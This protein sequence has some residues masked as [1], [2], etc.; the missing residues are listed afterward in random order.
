MSVKII[1]KQISMSVVLLTSMSSLSAENLLQVYKHAL[2]ADPTLKAAEAGFLATMENKP[3]A[4]ASKK[5]QVGFSGSTSY[6]L[7]NVENTAA[8]GN[9]DSY[10]LG[11]DLSLSK[12]IYRKDLDALVD[13]ATAGVEQSRSLLEVERQ[14][15]IIRVADAYFSYLSALDSLEFATAEKQA[16]NR[17]LAQ[18]KAFFEAGRSPITD[19]KEA[20]ARYD[21]AVSQEVAAN[22]QL[23]LAN[24]QI[25][26]IT[27][28]Y[29]KSLAR[30]PLD[31]PLTPPAPNKIEAWTKMAL[32]NSSEIRALKYAVD[33]AQAE[34]DRQRAVKKPTV[35]LFARQS[36]NLNR[37]DI[38]TEQ[39][40]ASLGVQLS[41]PLYQGGAIPSR[42]RQSRHNLHQA[43][44]QLEARKRSVNQQARSAYLS[45]IS[46]IAQVKALRQALRSSET[47]AQATQAG[48]EVGTRTAVDVLLSL[49]ETF[50]ARRDYSSARYEYLLNRLRL[51]QA[52]GTLSNKDLNE[53]NQVLTVKGK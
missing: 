13:S 11:Y 52:V 6:N 50:G 30:A 5:P 8:D 12:S 4:L 15:L 24:E 28:R 48:F 7:R 35:D 27:G 40:D 9:F 45:V 31:T 3:Q 17:Q 14:G 1:V 44:H 42:I 41:V 47:A 38:D 36:G 39:L 26:A 29:Y 25:K 19:V 34:V 2:D 23:D 18:V 51:K 33:V 32:D 22:Q 21:T 46:G 10:N 49:R 16:I 43:Q 53:I 37:V 20:Q